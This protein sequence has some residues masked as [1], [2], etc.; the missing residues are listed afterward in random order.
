LLN[1][2]PN[3]LSPRQQ[4][5]ATTEGFGFPHDNLL[6]LSGQFGYGFHGDPSPALVEE[7]HFLC[8]EG[9]CGKNWGC[10]K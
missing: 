6:R 3:P 4:F 2:L 9:A 7:K 8:R 5:F 1:R 10:V